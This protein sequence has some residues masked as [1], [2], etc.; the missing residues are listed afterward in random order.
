MGKKSA[1]RRAFEASSVHPRATHINAWVLENANRAAGHHFFDADTKRFFSSRISNGF[2]VPGKLAVYFV[3]S[4]K[5]RW[6]SEPRLYTVRLMLANGK[7]ADIPGETFQGHRT[8]ASATRAAK[9][10][11]GVK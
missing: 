11:A 4:E 7:L 8:L 6:S 10:L 1:L 3:T 2:R 9:R 5:Q